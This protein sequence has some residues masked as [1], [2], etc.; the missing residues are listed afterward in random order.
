MKKL[1]GQEFTERIKAVAKA[2]K[3]LVPHIA[4]NISVAITLYQEVHAE[5]ERDHFLTS[6]SAHSSPG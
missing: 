4:K 1:T 6:I 2:R 5:E 3:V